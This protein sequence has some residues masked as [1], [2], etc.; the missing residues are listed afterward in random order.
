MTH[1]RILTV[2]L[3]LPLCI[4][5]CSKQDSKLYIPDKKYQLSKRI[6]INTEKRPM[7]ISGQSIPALVAGQQIDESEIISFQEYIANAEGQKNQFRQLRQQLKLRQDQILLLGLR[8][9]GAP[10]VNLADTQ[11]FSDVNTL[12]INH[13]RLLKRAQP[14]LTTKLNIDLGRI[15]DALNLN[16]QPV[17]IPTYFDRLN[18][19]AYDTEQGVLTIQTTA[20]VV[21][22]NDLSSQPE[23]ERI[24][25]L[26][27]QGQ[28][29]AEQ[30]QNL[31][32]LWQ[33]RVEKPVY[34]AFVLDY[35]PQGI[36]IDRIILLDEKGYD[37]GYSIISQMKPKQIQMQEISPDLNLLHEQSIALHMLIPFRFGFT[38]TATTVGAS[39]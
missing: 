32:D 21:H 20:P 9:R 7:V 5:A 35:Q 26:R 29:S 18:R 6:E 33:G 14:T 16:Y 37:S 2:C 3:L 13:L 31:L 30:A 15:E 23:D 19:V 24:Q 17:N 34:L 22:E 10:V 38:S 11:M 39:S 25:V 8:G 36:S 1:V 27:F 4:S 28:T 12:V